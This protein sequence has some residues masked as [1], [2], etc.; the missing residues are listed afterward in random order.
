MKKHIVVIDD[1]RAIRSILGRQLPLYDYEVH[2]CDSGQ[3]GLDHV[4]ALVRTTE[5]EV[6]LLDWMMPEMSGLEVLVKLKRRSL[7]RD[8]PIFMLTSKSKMDDL[9]MA[10]DM[11]ADNYIT[12]PFRVSLIG[13]I[14]NLKLAKLREKKKKLE[15]VS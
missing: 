11:G 9:D 10:F 6:I 12:K 8:I 2:C 13:S 5:I 7:T 3:A 14:I 1:E 15:G 4:M